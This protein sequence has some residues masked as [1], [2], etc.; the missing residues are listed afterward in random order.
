MGLSTKDRTFLG[1][2]DRL[3]FLLVLMAALILLYILMVPSEQIEWV[4][5][6][7]G[8]ALCGVFL[9]TQKLLSFITELDFELRKVVNIVKDSLPE[10]QRK[11]LY[12]DG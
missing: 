11:K 10:E 9:L 3:K 8:F 7:I 4:T 2:I 12:P 6:V 1:V 5:A